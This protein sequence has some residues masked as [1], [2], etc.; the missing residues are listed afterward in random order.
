MFKVSFRENP[1]F[2]NK[3]V[4]RLNDGKV[5]LVTLLGVVDMPVFLQ[6]FMPREI[7]TWMD[8]CKNVEAECNISKM[9]IIARGKAVR[10]DG[11]ADDPVLGERIAECRAKINLYRFMAKLTG[12]LYVYYG[13]L[14]STDTSTSSH[15]GD[16]TISGANIKYCNLGSRELAHLK[17]LLAHEP[18]TESTPES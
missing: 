16:D 2:P 5:T 14:L 1:I 18:D 15:K 12:K 3:K 17:A 11:D 9:H 13:K 4:Q 7:L 6:Y 10:A 8:T